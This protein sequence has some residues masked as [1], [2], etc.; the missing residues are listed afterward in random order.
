MLRRLTY[1]MPLFLLLACVSPEE[2]A[3]HQAAAAAAQEVADQNRCMIQGFQE[4]TDAFAQC[5]RMTIDQQRRPHRC[6]YCRSV[7]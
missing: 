3:R 7:D 1:I 6:T 4:G 2:E 5:V